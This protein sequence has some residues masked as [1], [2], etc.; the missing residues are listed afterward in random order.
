MPPHTTLANIWWEPLGLWAFDTTNPNS[1]Q[2]GTTAVLSR[3][4]ADCVLMQ[5]TKKHIPT[6]D[7]SWLSRAGRRLGWS[8][9]ASSARL[10]VAG[11]ASGG[12][13]V[14]ARRGSGIR[15]LDLVTEEYQFRQ[16]FVHFNGCC[17]GGIDCGSVWMK[18]S[19][20]L[21][22]T[23]LNLLSCLAASIG[24]LRGP[25]LLGGDW[26]MD[27]ATLSSYLECWLPREALDKAVRAATNKVL[28]VEGEIR[29][30]AV[31][32]PAGA[33]VAS[34]RRIGWHFIGGHILIADDGL[35][36]NLQFDRYPPASSP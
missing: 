21:S 17:R 8:R 35:T 31:T 10:T 23:N 24:G 27:P 2:S 15:P 29:W 19:E 33:S 26:H 30:N 11:R 3:S 36:Y 7:P 28:T 13:A 20:G 22:E 5:K 32:C 16:A 18:D 25:W 9:R 34:L 1:W 4:S 14:L 6:D 12:V